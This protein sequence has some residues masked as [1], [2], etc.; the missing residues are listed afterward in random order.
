MQAAWA[1]RTVKMTQNVTIFRSCAAARAAC[2]MVVSNAT[3]PRRWA[4]QRQR[5]IANANAISN[6]RNENFDYFFT[7]FFDGFRVWDWSN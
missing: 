2:G 5:R 4:L 3:F 1:I 7:I 6:A